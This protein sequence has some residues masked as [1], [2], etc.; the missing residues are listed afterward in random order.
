MQDYFQMQNKSIS[1]FAV[2]I[3][4]G[5][6]VKNSEVFQ[7]VVEWHYPFKRRGALFMDMFIP[8]DK[9]VN[10]DMTQTFFLLCY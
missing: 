2:V 5:V 8:L 1:Y 4:C 3:C 7:R 10:M 9:P 6:L